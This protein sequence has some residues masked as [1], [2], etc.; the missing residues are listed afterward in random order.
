MTLVV[1][2]RGAGDGHCPCAMQPILAVYAQRDLPGIYRISRD[3]SVSH[4]SLARTELKLLSLVLE[5]V[6]D[7]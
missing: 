4:F 5:N 2:R 1:N 7:N 3:T 6:R